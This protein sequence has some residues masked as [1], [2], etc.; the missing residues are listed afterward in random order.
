EVRSRLRD[1]ESRD[2]LYDY[3]LSKGVFKLGLRIQCSCCSR[4]SWFALADVGDTFRCPRCLSVFPAVGNLD[5]AV[6][7]YRTAGPFSVPNYADGA[8]AVLLAVDFFNEHRLPTLRTTSVL[9]FVADAP[10]R[11]NLEADFALL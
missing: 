9:S 5:A 4:R 6:W 1:P 10:N 7:S 3:L 11:K 8:Y 2:N